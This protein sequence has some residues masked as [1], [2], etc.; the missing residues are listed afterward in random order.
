MVS[1]AEHKPKLSE[2]IKPTTSIPCG[3]VNVCKS[4][5][6]RRKPKAVKLFGQ[7]LVVWRDNNRKAV[8]MSEYCAHQGASLAQGRVTDGRIECP[9]HKAQFDNCGICTAIPFVTHIPQTLAQHTYPTQERYGYIW[10]WHGTSEPLWDLPEFAPDEAERK[11]YMTLRFSFA[12]N[13]TF[14]RILE[15]LTDALHLVTLHKMQAL[16]E[17]TVE[18]SQTKTSFSFRAT[19]KPKSYVGFG[20]YLT[21]LIGLDIQ[22]YELVAYS[23]PTTHISD[24]R[25]NGEQKFISLISVTTHSEYENNQQVLLKVK[26]TGKWWLDAIYFIAFGLQIWAAGAQDIPIWNGMDALQGGAYLPIDHVTLEYRKFFSKW[27]AAANTNIYQM[28]DRG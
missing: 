17:P 5:K 15:N 3:W 26:K 16:A 11:S 1:S 12:T 22:S 19:I 8:L 7:K 9:F 23:T 14:Q 21:K 2:A 18:F 20:K 10:A 13:T 4:S 24:S 6:V 25:I 28:K 27:V